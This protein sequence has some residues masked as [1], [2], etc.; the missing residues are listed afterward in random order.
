M[1]GSALAGL[2]SVQCS[3]LSHLSIDKVTSI[4]IHD[5][6]LLIDRPNPSIIRCKIPDVCFFDQVCN[7]LTFT[8]EEDTCTLPIIDVLHQTKVGPTGGFCEEM[9]MMFRLASPATRYSAVSS[10]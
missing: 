5:R 1:D 8:I 6:A 4:E 2:L 3:L 9:E 10:Y 7:A